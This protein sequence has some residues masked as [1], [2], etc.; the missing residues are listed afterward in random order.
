LEKRAMNYYIEAKRGGQEE[1]DSNGMGDV[2]DPTT[3][4]GNITGAILGGVTVQLWA[5]NCG[6]DLDGGSAVTDSAGYYA[7]GGVEEFRH[8]VEFDAPGYSFAPEAYWAD[9]PHEPGISNDATSTA[10]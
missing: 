6:G 2:C 1:A 8:T 9:I 7:I 5:L 4:Y 10:D 3:V